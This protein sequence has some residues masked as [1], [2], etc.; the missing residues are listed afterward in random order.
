MENLPLS[1]ELWL[2]LKWWWDWSVLPRAGQLQRRSSLMLPWCRT[3]LADW[4]E[5]G[6]GVCVS[7]WQTECHARCRHVHDSMQVLFVTG[8]KHL[9]FPALS[10]HKLKASHP[11]RGW[12]WWDPLFREDLSSPMNSCRVTGMMACGP[13]VHSGCPTSCSLCLTL[14]R[15]PPLPFKSLYITTSLLSQ[16]YGHVPLLLKNLPSVSL[17][18]LLF[19]L[20]MIQISSIIFLQSLLVLRCHFLFL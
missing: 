1:Q 3:G 2:C 9:F 19:P 17:L 6:R 5:K 8:L 16:G 13:T 20:V 4:W 12:Q 10:Q 14:R 15:K 18:A 11:G 7:L